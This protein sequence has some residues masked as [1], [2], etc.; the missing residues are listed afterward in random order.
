MGIDRRLFVASL[1]F[2]LSNGEPISEDVLRKLFEEFGTVIDL[3]LVR[4]F[5]THRPKGYAF[6]EF[7]TVDQANAAIRGLHGVEFHGRSIIVQLANPRPGVS[8][9]VHRATGR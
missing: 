2:N 5:S 9:A 6:I 7:Q 4:D 1:P 8:G 3:L